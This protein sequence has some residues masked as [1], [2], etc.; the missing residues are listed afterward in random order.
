MNGKFDNT[1]TVMHNQLVTT[2][3]LPMYMCIKA[4][5]GSPSR[6]QPAGSVVCNEDGRIASETVFNKRAEKDYYKAIEKYD[7]CA[8]RRQEA[9][10]ED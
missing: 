3:V 4:G 10:M 2:I 7:V 5:E 1:V 8:R 6:E 9:E